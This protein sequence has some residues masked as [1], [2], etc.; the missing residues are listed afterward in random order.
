MNKNELWKMIKK[1]NNVIP[2]KALEYYI[3]YKR[4]GGKR[5]N[6]KYEEYYQSVYRVG[7]N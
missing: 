7:T 6:K 3:T 5:V 2:Q 1:Y 4:T